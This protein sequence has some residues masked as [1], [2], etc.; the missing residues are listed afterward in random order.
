MFDS[1]NQVVALL[2]FDGKRYVHCACIENTEFRKRPDAASLRKQGYLVAFLKPQF[3]KS[4]TY[5]VG[6][7]AGLLIGGFHPFA[8]D[9]FTKESVVGIR[10]CVLLDKVDDGNSFAHNIILYVYPT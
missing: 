6:F 10:P 3:H 9:F 2:K 7:L 4:C 1:E 8:V 5:P